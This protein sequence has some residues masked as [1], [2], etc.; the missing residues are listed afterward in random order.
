MEKGLFTFLV[1]TLMVPLGDYFGEDTILPSNFDWRE[2]ALTTNY[3]VTGKVSCNG[4][5]VVGV[6]VSDGV[7]IAVTDSNG[8]YR[9]NSKKELGYVFVS[10]PSGYEVSLD[11]NSPL[12]FKYL[13]SKKDK[14]VEEADFEL[15]K[16]DNEKHAVLAMAD[17]HLAA[18][19]DDIK[20]FRKVADDIN[21][22]ISDLKRQGYKVYGISLGDES[23]DIY[24]YSNHFTIR[25][26]KEQMK[27]IKAPVFHNMGNHDGNPYKQGD[28]ASSQKF[29]D[30]CGPKYYSFNLGKVHYVV[31]DNTEYINEN[32][33]EGHVGK[34]NFRESI[35]SQQMNWLKKDLALIDNSHTPI[36][37]AMHSPIYKHPDLKNGK[38]TCDYLLKNGR[39]LE[40]V[41]RRFDNVQVL[42]G[43]LHKAHHLQQTAHIIDHNTPAICGTWWW[44]DKLAGNSVCQDGSPSG[45]GVYLWQ[46]NQVKW[47]Y[48]SAAHSRSYQFRSYDLNTTWIAPKSYAPKFIK[49]MTQYA[50][51]YATCRND[52]KVL[53]NV[54]NYDPDWTVEVSENGKKLDVT[55][56]QMYDPLHI[57]SY[58]AIRV[59][60]GGARLV[61]FPTVPTSHMFM[62][63][64][65]H[66][67]TT[68]LIRVT[69]RF[70]NI[71][72]EKMMR[73]KAFHT[74]MK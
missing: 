6:E 62:V 72:Q 40:E 74:M 18:Q 26:A 56:V 5:G 28:R 2:Q 7:E 47:Y 27:I 38:E 4:E 59:R 31:L 29:I 67:N 71:Y 58:D 42:S 39:E 24:W 17:F 65:N 57:I 44:T 63:Q 73:P 36:V 9:L 68:L 22:S 23:W 15:N 51:N 16:V 20:Q 69:D 8:V 41:L 32:G 33:R 3:T 54:W 25:E 46:G 12:F 34:I 53:I 55:Q 37:I 49:D 45:Y 30:A 61:D 21:S 13:D 50:H 10:I 60:R 70:G 19:N 1:L 52:N 66:P 43:H 48:K 35:E 14:S 11:G 64:A